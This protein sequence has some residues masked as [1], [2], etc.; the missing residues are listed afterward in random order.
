MLL[1][2]FLFI[3]AV[4][5]CAHAAPPEATPAT[6][7]LPNIIL[8]TL[9]TTRADR[10]DFLGSKRALTPNL[11]VLARDASVFTRAYS[12][13]PLTPTSHATILTGTYPQFHQ[14]VPS[15]DPLN[16]D[17]PYLPDIL[18]THGYATAAFIGALALNLD[19][20]VGFDRGFD[21]YDAPYSWKG[22]TPKTRYQTVENRG[23]E[24]AD[25]ALAWVSKHQQ[26]PFFIWV[27]LFDPHEPY[28]PP[29][30]Y[31]TRYAKAPYDGEIAYVDSVMG[32]FFGQLKASGLY[33]GAL[34]A[35]TSDHG[36]SLGA[37][38]ENTHGV[39]LYDETIHV[40]LVIKLPGKCDA[41]TRVESRVELT[42]VLPT[43]LE[44]AGIQ[45]PKQV[46]G[47]SLLKL[48]EPGPAGKEEAEAWHDRGAY[49]QADYGRIAYGWSSLQSL[50]SGKYLYVQAPRREL[51]E[52]GIDPKAEHNVAAASSAVADT[53]SAKLKAFQQ[54]TANPH[55]TTLAMLDDN[56]MKQLAALG[57]MANLGSAPDAAGPVQRPDPK[58]VIEVEN[59]IYEANRVLQDF[60]CEQ[61]VPKLDKMIAVAPKIAPLHFFVGRCYLENK[62]YEKAIPELRAAVKLTPNFVQDE[63]NLGVALMHVQEFDEAASA[64]EHVL[65]TQPQ[66]TD[67]HIY[68]VVVYGAANRPEDQIREC[69][70]VLKILPG[71]FGADLNLGRALLKTGDLPGAAAALQEAIAG[72]PHDRMGRRADSDR[73]SAEAERLRT[74]LQVQPNRAPGESPGA[75]E[76]R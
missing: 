33:D 63:M 1:R 14:V 58:D 39:F 60:R 72:E 53:L 31:K 8:I 50:R 22:Y 70:A 65:K 23:G 5:S 21:V 34:I 43:L 71:N 35:L 73:E 69:H 49:S 40:P 38:G 32:K 51:Y 16:K 37:H 3:F 76:Q 20:A 64:F 67:A 41:G 30:P 25:R 54:E 52:D 24:V 55:P 42:D 7:R 12:Q 61:A 26:G 45:I 59:V 13:A 66:L 47:A 57:Y 29:E 4:A 48:M 28:D 44:N 17:L 56:R 36:E 6:P 46:Q 10:M 27:H 74:A 62:E 11:D 2:W 15:P 9:D 68:L 75:P 19:L 18:K